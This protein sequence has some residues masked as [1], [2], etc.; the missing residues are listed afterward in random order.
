[1]ITFQYLSY[2]SKDLF[3]QD[4]TD[5]TLEPI[6]PKLYCKNALYLLEMKEAMHVDPRKTNLFRS[7]CCRFLSNIF[8]LIFNDLA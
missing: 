1:M 3:D 4:D 5:Q 7:N 2:G 6:I 8:K